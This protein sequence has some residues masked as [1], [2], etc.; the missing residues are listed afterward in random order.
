MILKTS[1][2][3]VQDRKM[4]G[5][6]VYNTRAHASYLKS[7]I[8]QVKKSVTFRAFSPLGQEGGHNFLPVHW[9]NKKENAFAASIP[10]LST[11]ASL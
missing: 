10:S 6:G 7:V 11:D 8:W 4:K 5:P 1:L 2:M 9:W 3:E